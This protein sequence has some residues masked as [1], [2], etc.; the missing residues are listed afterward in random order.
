MKR[1]VDTN[2]GREP[3]FRKLSPKFKCAIRF[4]FD[5]CNPIGIWVIDMET[6]G[7]FIGEP[8]ELSELFKEVNVDKEDRL[9]LL[10]KDKLFIPGFVDFQ[11]G[12]L[13]ETCKPHAKYISLLKK[14]KLFERVCKGYVKGIHTLEEKEEEKDKEEEKEERGSGGKPKPQ[15]SKPKLSVPRDEQLELKMSYD[16]LAKALQDKTENEAW[17]EVKEF[18]ET[19]KPQ[20]IEPYLDAWNFLANR[21]KLPSVKASS[22]GRLAKFKARIREPMFDFVKILAA[23]SKSDYLKG[24]TTDWNV[25]FDWVFENDT[26]YLKILEGKFK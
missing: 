6:M 5:E 9:E 14:H 3:W 16:R 18:L 8:I 7:Y 13:T 25:D 10:G 23:I 24:K 1:Y 17:I 26:N 15:P 2:L 22:T 12:E 19:H 4:L 21:Y 11:Y 20:F